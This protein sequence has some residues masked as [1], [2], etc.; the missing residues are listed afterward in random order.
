MVLY[1]NR[2]HINNLLILIDWSREGIGIPFNSMSQCLNRIPRG[3]SDRLDLVFFPNHYY[4]IC[5][6]SWL[7]FLITS[8][9]LFS[10]ALG[11]SLNADW[12]PRRILR[13]REN[14]TINESDLEQKANLSPTT[15]ADL[16]HLAQT[17]KINFCLIKKEILE[18]I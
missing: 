3:I 12:N 9:W 17:P 8:I 10:R 18:S 16:N 2:I 13:N 4:R 14:S 15:K 1:T 6:T 7:N 5:H 11:M